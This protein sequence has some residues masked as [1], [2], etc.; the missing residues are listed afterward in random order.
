VP[1]NVSQVKSGL[2]VKA[3][4]TST[5]IHGHFPQLCNRYLPDLRGEAPSNFSKV[6]SYIEI[7]EGKSLKRIGAT[8]QSGEEGVHG[9]QGDYHTSAFLQMG[10]DSMTDTEGDRCQAV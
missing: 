5:Q 10:Y 8:R 2:L 1:Q 7:T 9:V 4:N 3:S 6:H